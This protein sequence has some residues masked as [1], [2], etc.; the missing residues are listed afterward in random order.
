MDLRDVSVWM[1][2]VQKVWIKDGVGLLHSNG[3]SD[4]V[5]VVATT[6]CPTHVEADVAA[7]ICPD[8]GSRGG[9]DDGFPDH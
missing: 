2:I 3:G 6:F 9:S 1:E 7:I 4:A 8:G 5:D